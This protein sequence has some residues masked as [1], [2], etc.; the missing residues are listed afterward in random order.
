MQ[1]FFS[2]KH[3]QSFTAFFSAYFSKALK[4]LFFFSFQQDDCLVHLNIVAS[5][6]LTAEAFGLRW[7]WH[8]DAWTA[9]VVV[10]GEQ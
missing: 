10:L 2:L 6:Q 8:L 9:A 4:L 7:L 1:F 5:H 3:R